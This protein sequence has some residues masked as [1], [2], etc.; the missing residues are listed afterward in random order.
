[1]KTLVKLFAILLI[2]T[3]CVKYTGKKTLSLS[4]TYVID[5]LVTNDTTYYVGDT[6]NDSSDIILPSL[7]TIY[8]Y[9]I[10][11]TLFQMDYSMIRFDPIQGGTYWL[12]EY[13]Y[14]VHG[15]YTAYDYGYIKFD[16][17]GTRRV[18]KIIDDTAE[19][20]VLR[21]SGGWDNGNS[22]NKEV[23]TMILSRVGP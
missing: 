10:G 7:D 5:K 6:F 9:I 3:S 12:N 11:D 1:M 15:Q 23:T 2:L 13:Y 8:S 22:G 17:D 20:L 4:G 19:G 14:F 18:W 16:C 21:T